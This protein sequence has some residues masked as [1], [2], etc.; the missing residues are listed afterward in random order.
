MLFRV[1]IQV[2][3]VKSLT[4]TRSG[5]ARTDEIT[6]FLSGAGWR[7]AELD[8]LPGDAS[9]RRYVRVHNANNESAMLM[10]APPDLEDVRPF[11]TIDEYL[12]EQ[13]Y[14]APSCFANNCDYGLLLLED[15]GDQLFTDLLSGA[16]EEAE[17]RTLYEAAIDLLTDWYHNEKMHRQDASIDLPDHGYPEL[18]R[19]LTLFSEWYVPALR[20]PN[21]E[22]LQAGYLKAWEAV[23][24]QHQPTGDIF[25]H[26]DFHAGNLLWLDARDDRRQVGILDFQDALWGNPAYDLVSL[27]ED[28]RRDVNP[29]LADSMFNRYAKA[30][31]LNKEE[32][33][34]D[35]AILGAQRNC[36]ILGIFVRL[37]VRDK[38]PHYL[39]FLPRVWGYLQQD[40]K[41]P[42]LAPLAEWF[43]Q[44]ATS[45][46]Q[47]INA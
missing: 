28:A 30:T 45:D 11:L 23:W 15:L 7:G 35:Y 16:Y 18:L 40:L 29:Q 47:T 25:V 34:R 44:N 21:T 37:C 27:L 31:G 33:A 41:H 22:L 24:Q 3:M 12:C 6:A 17:E 43:E 39:E 20:E 13:G 26:R 9:F 2:I 5:H 14:S 42:A 32:L 46:W 19:E 36:K 4:K 8:H 38:K 1:T 10:D